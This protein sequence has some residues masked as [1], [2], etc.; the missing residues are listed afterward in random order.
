MVILLEDLR[1]PPVLLVCRE[2]FPGRGGVSS[3]GSADL[4]KGSW[5]VSTGGVDEDGRVR[6]GPSHWLIYSWSF[7][8]PVRVCGLCSEL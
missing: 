4:G 8:E 1:F 3:L 7:G 2:R 6:K 5:E